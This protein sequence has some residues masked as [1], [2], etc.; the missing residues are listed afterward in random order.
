MA[1]EFGIAQPSDFSA[2]ITLWNAGLDEWFPMT[3]RLLRQQLARIIHEQPAV[4]DCD[5]VLGM[6]E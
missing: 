2:L 6:I 5:D 1:V 4:V 3:E